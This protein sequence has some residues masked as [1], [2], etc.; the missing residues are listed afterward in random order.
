MIAKTPLIEENLPSVFEVHTRHGHPFRWLHGPLKD[1]YLVI[2]YG[3]QLGLGSR[4]YD[5]VDVFPVEKVQRAEAVYI[6]AH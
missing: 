6:A 4:T 5:L 3:E 1:P 2:V